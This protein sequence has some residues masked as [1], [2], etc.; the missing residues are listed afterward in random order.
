M[1][2]ADNFTLFCFF[3]LSFDSVL[4]ELWVVTL[5]LQDGF[6]EGISI[7]LGPQEHLSNFSFSCIHFQ[8][9]Q[10]ELFRIVLYL[11]GRNFAFLVRVLI[12]IYWF[13]C[14]F[15]SIHYFVLAYE[16]CKTLDIELQFDLALV[17]GFDDKFI[18]KHLDY[19]LL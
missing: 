11:F 2:G 3:Y 13:L 17:D 18:L 12:L 7:I 10:V 5:S 8:F 15:N 14:A 4:I 19:V 1:S 9:H 16:R 6:N